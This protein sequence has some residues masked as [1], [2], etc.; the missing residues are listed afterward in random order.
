MAYNFMR[1]DRD[2]PFLLPPTCATGCPKATSPG[3][4][5]TWSADG[6]IDIGSQVTR[7]RRPPRRLASRA[8]GD[9]I[10]ASGKSHANLGRFWPIDKTR[11]LVDRLRSTSSPAA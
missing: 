2:Q 10:S 9:H 8:V 4:S 11:G 6:H 5:S 1:G 7:L 3:A